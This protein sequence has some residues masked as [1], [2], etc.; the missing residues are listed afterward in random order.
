[1]CIHEGVHDPS[2]MTSYSVLRGIITTRPTGI[3]LI[4]YGLVRCITQNNHTS[5]MLAS[6]TNGGKG[7]LEVIKALLAAGADMEV[8]D[9]V[10][11]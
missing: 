4:Q 10:S 6:R 3:I 1:M 2:D 11:G 8:K 5:L 9:Q 7:Y